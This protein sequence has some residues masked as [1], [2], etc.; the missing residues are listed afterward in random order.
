MCHSSPAKIL[1]SVKRMTKF[2]EKKDIQSISPELS[3]PILSCITLQQIDIP[4]SEKLL[5]LSTP[6]LVSI[7]PQPRKLSGCNQLPTEMVPGVINE[8]EIAF[9]TY[10]D[11]FTQKT[12]FICNFCY[13]DT[14]RSTQSMRQHL[15]E[16]HKI[17]I[18][19]RP[20]YPFEP[21]CECTS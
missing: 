8:D 16:V 13:C 20:N 7:Q 1:Q 15:Q 21:R 5:S 9:N 18:R 6:T 17:C 3:K 19:P 14:L 2:N 12:I 11:G 4:P 10:I